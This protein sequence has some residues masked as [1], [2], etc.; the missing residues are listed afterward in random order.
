MR[1][2]DADRVL[3]VEMP[4]G[5]DML[6]ISL[7]AAG[8]E[9]DLADD[10]EIGLVLAAARTP[11]VIICEIDLPVMDGWQFARAVRT[12]FAD[13]VRLI[14]LTARGSAD[15]QARSRAAGFDAHLVKPVPTP[16]VQQTIRQLL[17]A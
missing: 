10:A 5:R 15:D 4:N 6:K 11:G 8:F 12:M 3:L 14:A 7:E 13:Q 17:A 1:C 16:D 2:V 9:V